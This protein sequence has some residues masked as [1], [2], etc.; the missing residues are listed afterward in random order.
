MRL[1]ILLLF[2]GCFLAQ[3]LKSATPIN[4]TH[5]ISPVRYKVRLAGSFGELRG[6]HFHAGLDIKSSQ[7]RSGDS[8]FAAEEGY[9]SRIRIQRAGYGKSIYV[10]HPNGYTTVYAHLDGYNQKLEEYVNRKQLEMQSYEVDILPEEGMFNVSKGEH[11]AFLG[12]TGIS[13]G[14]HLHFEIRETVTDKAMNPFLFGIT[15]YDKTAP[16]ITSVRVTGLRPDFHKVYDYKIPFTGRKKKVMKEVALEVP[17]WRAGIGIAAHDLMD[18]SHN[19][20]GIYKLEMWVDDTLYYQVE[21][22]QFLLKETHLIDAHTRFEVARKNYSTEVLCYRMPGNQLSMVQNDKQRGLI[23]L[24]KDS[25]RRVE[26]KVS[27]FSGNESR[28]RFQIKRAASFDAPPVKTTNIKHGEY[29]TYSHKNLEVGFLPQSLARDIAF[30]VSST[31]DSLTSVYH[32]GDPQEPILDGV[33]LSVL[34]PE[35]HREKKD[36][37]C[38]ARLNGK[39]R[40]TD[41][42]QTLKGDSLITVTTD[43]GKYGFVVDEKAPDIIPLSF[44]GNPRTQQFRFKIRDNIQTANGAQAFTYHVWIDGQ[45]LPCDFRSLSETLTVPIGQLSAGAH[46]LV[47]EARDQFDNLSRWSAPFTKK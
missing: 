16:V 4:E 6:R 19:K 24:Y 37:L 32:I 14:P 1:S 30:E 26:L 42:G 17:A 7:G 25:W 44:S 35:N 27:D 23:N 13:Y 45:W 31:G 38:F 12:N 41:Y 29:Q 39:G 36:K 18:G 15:A 2:T 20:H 43:F 3:S 5:F 47:I 33:K 28:Y 10:N 21:Y 40:P 8:I 46:E 9:I 22:G 34:I 11:M